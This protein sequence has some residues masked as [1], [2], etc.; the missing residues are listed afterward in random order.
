LSNVV[1]YDSAVCVAVVHG[2]QGL[3]ALLTCG[4]PDLELDGGRVI[5]GDSLGQESGADGGFP[6]VVELVLDEAEDE[7]TLPCVRCVYSGV[8]WISNGAPFRRRI[9]L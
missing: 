6:V 7:R 1:D 5:E 2:G 3:V 8:V 9:R 4:I